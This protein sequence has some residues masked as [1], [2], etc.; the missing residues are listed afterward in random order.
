MNYNFGT[1][2]GEHHLV[3]SIAT[4]SASSCPAQENCQ[5]ASS[6]QRWVLCL[7]LLLL[8]VGAGGIRPNVIT[9]A[10]DQFDMTKSKVESRSW[11]FFNCLCFGDSS[12][13]EN[14][15]RGSP[16]VRL[17]QVIIAA[18]KKRKEVAP[19]DPRMLYQCKELD[20]LISSDG[21]LLHTDQLK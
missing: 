13:Q 3:S 16:L 20:A 21:K 8:S 11:N 1:G 15:T 9:F 7:S 19:E 14:K 12:L 6:Q 18:W 4:S 17:A 5:E 10:A 2:I